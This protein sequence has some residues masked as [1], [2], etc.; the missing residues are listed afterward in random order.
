MGKT[1][2]NIDLNEFKTR[3]GTLA[4]VTES[5]IPELSQ[6]VISSEEIHRL[7][8]ISEALTN[9]STGELTSV[10]NDVTV[11]SRLK[12]IGL[13]KDNVV[14]ILQMFD[15]EEKLKHYDFNSLKPDAKGQYRIWVEDPF[16]SK[17]KKRLYGRNIDILKEKVYEHD[18]GIRATTASITFRY[19]FEQAAL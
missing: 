16:A 19:A 13:S 18:K 7:L 15:R 12:D 8:S 6:N 17:G 10:T 14:N 5:Y 9:T 1:P 2:D 3:K 11:F 4:S